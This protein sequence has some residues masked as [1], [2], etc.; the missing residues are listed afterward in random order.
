MKSMGLGGCV[1]SRNILNGLGNVKWCIR[2][3]SCNELDNGWRFLSD[4]DTVE[5]LADSSNMAVC[6]WGTIVNI[7]P[8]VIEIFNMPVG[9]DIMLVNENNL[10][11][12]VYT[13]TGVEI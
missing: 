10:K 1:V 5:F 4:I 9:T 13:E 6:D 12:F 7:E 2:E 11:K 3:S 8:A